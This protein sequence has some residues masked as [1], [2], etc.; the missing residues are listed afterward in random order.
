MFFEVNY[1]PIF[2]KGSNL[3]PFD[4]F[5]P[6]VTVANITRM[7]DAAV[8]SHQNIIRIVGS[9]THTHTHRATC[10]ALSCCALSSSSSSLPFPPPDC[11]SPSL[12][13]PPL[14]WGGGIF[15]DDAVYDYAD[16]HGILL[17]QEFL[18][19]CG[20]Y[21]VDDFFLR[22]VREEVTQAVRRLASHASL[23]I[24]GGNNENEAALNWQQETITYRDR[25]LVSHSPYAHPL[26]ST[27][28]SHTLMLTQ[29]PYACV[30]CQVDYNEVS[31]PPHKPSLVDVPHPLTVR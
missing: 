26:H 2:A 11:Y 25:Y 7:L 12:S 4:A 15:Q 9:H 13:S 24:F 30:C 14:Q 5:H 21:S 20:F 3:V 1:I 29:P 31:D 23:A 27:S 8:A 18:F 17:W 6:R 16:A 19:A 22:S 28:L 10:T